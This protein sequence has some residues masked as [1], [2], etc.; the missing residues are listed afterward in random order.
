MDLTSLDTLFE[1]FFAADDRDDRAGL[2]LAMVYGIVKQNNGFI[3]V[4]S[5]HESGTTFNVYLPVHSAGDAGEADEPRPLLKGSE[6]ILLVEDDEA[7]LNM[8][9]LRLQS[10][11]YNV[12]AAALAGEAIRLAAEYKGPIHLLF[13]D[14]VMPDMNGKELAEGLKS[15]HAEMRCVFMSG[16]ASDTVLRHGILEEGVNFIRKPYS[17]NELALKI[18]EVLDRQA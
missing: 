5:Q 4:E 1:P 8:E 7:L 14:V 11:G 17:I 3:T 18:R 13:T 2:G 9:K 15:S 6:T 12:L 10:L 16:Y